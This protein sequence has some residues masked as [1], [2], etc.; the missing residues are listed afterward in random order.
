MSSDCWFSF[1]IVALAVSPHLNQ[2]YRHT[3]LALQRF[4]SVSNRKTRTWHQIY[5]YLHVKGST[6]S[7]WSSL[8]HSLCGSH[9]SVALSYHAINYFDVFSKCIEV[10]NWAAVS[11]NDFKWFHVV[12]NLIN[13][14]VQD[15][16]TINRLI[17]GF[18]KCYNP[19]LYVAGMLITLFYVISTKWFSQKCPP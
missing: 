9:N 14:F 4:T 5:G 10:T 2:L 18:T 13:C 6:W 11:P 8:C 17:R 16:G 12:H 7:Q 1:S 19:I 3:I 15:V